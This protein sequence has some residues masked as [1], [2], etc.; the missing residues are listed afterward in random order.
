MWC[1][2]LFRFVFT[3]ESVCSHSLQGLGNE[4][5][6]AKNHLLYAAFAFLRRAIH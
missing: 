2:F 4:H 3:A 1:E 6:D 5:I